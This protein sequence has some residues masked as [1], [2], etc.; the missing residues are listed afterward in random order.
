[1]RT[2]ISTNLNNPDTTELPIGDDGCIEWHPD[3]EDVPSWA[4]GLLIAGAGVLALLLVSLAC[5]LSTPVN[6]QPAPGTPGGP[7]VPTTYGA[8]RAVNR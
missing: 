3:G 2:S 5:L 6:P 8:P 7:P 4:L 1:M